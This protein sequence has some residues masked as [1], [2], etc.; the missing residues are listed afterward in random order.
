MTGEAN[1]SMP[2]ISLTVG[3]F[4]QPLFSK[5]VMEMPGKTEKGISQRLLWLIPKPVYSKFDS[6]QSTDKDF[7][8]SI[9]KAYTKVETCLHDKIYNIS[10]HVRKKCVPY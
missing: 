1:F 5:T 6:L 9:G 8:D 2:S 4:N 3:G 7:V 10:L